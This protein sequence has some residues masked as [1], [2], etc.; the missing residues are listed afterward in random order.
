M[1]RRVSRIASIAAGLLIAAPAFA[2]TLEEVEK[3]IVEAQSKHKTVQ[4]KDKTNSESNMPGMMMKSSMDST[5]ELMRKGD[6]FLS[7]ADVKSVNIT[8]MGDQPEQKIESTMTMIY[9]GQ[10]AY[11]INETAGM[12]S[13]MKMKPDA[14][15]YDPVNMFKTLHENFE[16]KLLPEEKLDGKAMYVIEL[17]GKKGQPENP[18]FSRIATYYSKDTG[19]AMKSVHFDKAGKQVGSSVASDVK[20]NSEIKPERFVFKAPEGV[21]VMDMTKMDMGK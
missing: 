3:K 4:Y 11:T 20:L 15:T 5:I 6:K 14:N 8:K 10:F 18:A 1:S 9:D 17:A 19:L 16:L 21:E 12:K 13:A 7:R 2:E